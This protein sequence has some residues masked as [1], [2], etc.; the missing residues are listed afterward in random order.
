MA[1]TS[2]M[3]ASKY[4]KKEDVGEGMLATISGFDKVNLALDGA[5]PQWKWVMQFSELDKPLV[6][7]G[8][9]IRLCEMIFNS[10][11]TD[12]WIGNKI[13][14]YNDPTIQFQGKF[15]GGIRLR[16]PKKTVQASKPSPKAIEDLDSD[17]PF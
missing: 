16:A 4:L 13:V 7:N 15:T 11:D 9:N 14:L 2:E 10:G 6:L 8:T 5:P 12:D 3:L 1:K 17:I